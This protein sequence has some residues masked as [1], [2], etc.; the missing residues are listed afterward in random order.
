M[1]GTIATVDCG[2]NTIKLLIG[3]LPRV[4]VRESRTVRLGQGVDLPAASPTRRSSGPSPPS[5]T[6]PR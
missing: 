3:D 1:S 2:T 4:D 5:T 6:M